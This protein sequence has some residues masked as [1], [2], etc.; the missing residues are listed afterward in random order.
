MR[1]PEP[2]TGTSDQQA[3]AAPIEPDRAEADRFLAA[4]DPKAT[5]FKPSTTTKNARKSAK[6]RAKRTRSQGYSTARWP[7]IGTRWSS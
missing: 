7:N 4:L 5:K 3:H 1:N 2:G 6:P